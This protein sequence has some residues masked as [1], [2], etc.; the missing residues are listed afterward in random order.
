MCSRNTRSNIPHRK[1]LHE[2]QPTFSTQS[3]ARMYQS[4]RL[5]YFRK[6]ENPFSCSETG[7]VYCKQP[8]EIRKPDLKFLCAFMCLFPVKIANNFRSTSF[9]ND[10]KY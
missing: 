9:C 3:L 6:E 10:L 1:L 8:N 7:L 5:K 4:I 2:T